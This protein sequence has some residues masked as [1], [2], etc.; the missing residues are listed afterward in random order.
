MIGNL[1]E[2]IKY[3]I[4]GLKRSQ[5]TKGILQ[6]KKKKKKTPMNEWRN[7]RNYGLPNHRNNLFATKISSQ[8]VSQDLPTHHIFNNHVQEKSG[9]DRRIST[10]LEEQN[11]LPAEQKLCHPGSKRCKDQKQYLRT[12]K[13]GTEI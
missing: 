11:L 12:A 4:I 1:L 8:P 2:V 13:G 10:T 5:L 6:K 9:I 7:R 3:K